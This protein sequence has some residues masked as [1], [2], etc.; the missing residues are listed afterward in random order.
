MKKIT[1]TINRYKF[2]NLDEDTFDT[3]IVNNQIMRNKYIHISVCIPKNIV[4]SIVSLSKKT[5]YPIPINL[6]NN[7]LLLYY[8]LNEDK[9]SVYVI[10][11]KCILFLQSH[12]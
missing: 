6:E 1:D 3:K 9:N 2:S 11:Y 12:L 4:L 5:S 7:E 10:P 8:F